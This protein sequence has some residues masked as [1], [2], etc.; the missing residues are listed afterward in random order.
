MIFN[1]YKNLLPYVLIPTTFCGYATGISTTA[2]NQKT[3]I[4]TYSTWIGYTSIGIF[5]GLTYPVSFPLCAGYV[6]YG[7]YKENKS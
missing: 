7:Q 1:M 4:S 2:L 5:T 6:L 3:T